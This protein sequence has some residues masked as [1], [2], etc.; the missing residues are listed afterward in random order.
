MDP[1]PFLRLPA[2]LALLR[3]TVAGL[4]MAHS[5]VR[6]ANESIPQFG[7]F[8]SSR[9][10]PFGV[11]LVWAITIWELGGGMALIA[12]RW[13]QGVTAG[14]MI[15]L[16]VGIALI[17]APLGWFVGEHGTGGSEYSVALLAALVVI[18]AAD[19]PV[20]G[21]MRSTPEST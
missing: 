20:L 18:A 6:L 12:N 16:L 21:V 10:L 3:V 15:L 2:A 7:D 14:F 17:H 9:G 5:V 19:R 8:L 11:P 4:F 1:F 13:V